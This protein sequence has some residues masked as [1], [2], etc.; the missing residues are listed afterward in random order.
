MFK[1]LTNPAWLFTDR[2]IAVVVSDSVIDILE[3]D[4]HIKAKK[5]HNLKI[6]EPFC[7]SNKDDVSKPIVALIEQLL[8]VLQPNFTFSYIDETYPKITSLLYT[9]MTSTDDVIYIPFI[10]EGIH[11][12]LLT[13]IIELLTKTDNKYLITTNSPYVLDNFMPNAIIKI[14]AREGLVD[15]NSKDFEYK[16]ITDNYN[17]WLEYYT[18]G[19]L[20][21]KGIL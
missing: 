1:L 2:K 15:E 21:L 11:P 3:F 4:R 20:W 17:N 13:T 16:A 6:F 14:K 12:S 18:T 9:L 7:L 10:E 5:Y 19:Q 8:R